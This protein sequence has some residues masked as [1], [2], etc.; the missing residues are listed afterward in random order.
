MRTHLLI[1]FTSLSVF[2]VIGQNVDRE[3]VVIEIG[4]GTWCQWCPGAAQGA[5]DMV[6]NGHDVAVI[7]NH[8]SDIYANTYS[9]AR[10]SYYGISG[11]PTAYFDGILEDGG[12]LMCPNPEGKYSTYLGLY[13][14]RMAVASPFTIEMFGENTSGN[15]WEVTLLIDKVGTANTSNCVVHLVL[16][17]SHIQQAWQGC[18]T[19][20][21]FV[22]RLMVPDQ[23]GTDLELVDDHQEISLEFEVNSGW[24]EDEIEVVA[25]IQ[26]NSGHE[27]YQA[28][29]S[30][31]GDLQP[32]LEA[33]FNV[34]DTSLCTGNTTL[35]TDNSTGNILT[36]TWVFE[37]GTP[38]TSTQENPTVL[39]N[40]AGNF[41]VTL[42][43]TDAYSSN[44][45]TRNDHIHVSSQPPQTPNVPGGP[46]ELC[47]N[48]DNTE[49][50]AT[51]SSLALTYNWV[52]EPVSAGTIVN[53]G[54]QTISVNWSDTF[55]GDASLKVKALNGCGESN[56]SSPL[57]IT[58]M[59]N[60]AIF[61]VTGGGMFCAGSEGVEVGLNG[62]ELNVKYRLFKNN[63]QTNTILN[64]TGE[65]LNF[66]IFN[67]EGYY[68][69][70]AISDITSCAVF[71]QNTANVNEID[72][73]VAYT[74][75]GGGEICEGE[76]GLPVG[77]ED[78]ESLVNYELFLN[79]EPT[80][81]VLQGNGQPLDFGTQTEEGVYSVL[82]TRINFPCT[83]MMNGP[84]EIDILPVPAAY[85]VTGGGSFCEGGQ[86]VEVGLSNS[87]TGIEYELYYFDQQTGVVVQGTG[88]P[89]SFG[90]VN[91]EGEYSAVGSNVT[92]TC[93]NPM[94]GSV[95]VTMVSLPEI[96]NLTGTGTWCEGTSGAV[97]GLDGSQTGCTYELFCNNSTTGVMLPGT[98]NALSFGAFTA[99]GTYH[100]EAVESTLSCMQLMAGTLNVS[101]A[102]LPLVP[103]VPEGPSSVD[104][105]Y[106]TESEY[107]TAGSSYSDSY[108]W[109]LNPVEAGSLEVTGLL[110]CLVSW[111]PDFLGDASIRVR[112]VNECGE[113]SWSE[114]ITVNVYSTV[115]IDPAAGNQRITVSPNPSNGIFTV[116]GQ[117][118][119]AGTV[120]LKVS[121]SL[122]SVI[123]VER[124]IQ[125]NGIWSKEI[126]LSG[127][128]GGVYFLSI[129]T[130]TGSYTCKL[131]LNK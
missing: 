31:L 115:G 103:L 19:E 53:N 17:E 60:P 102:F 37:G 82:A 27:I 93:I 94:N 92:T 29:C 104:L 87:E 76:G 16:T 119:K 86:G 128:P 12:G 39:Y 75:T 73:P 5:D 50:S 88:G 90:L 47:E 59:P 58:V 43:V 123:Y 15:D 4:T 69:V 33:D 57:P 10:N 2:S 24:D 30:P 80:G 112:G 63:N 9:N 3:K 35:F 105:M 71:M 1:L 67:E 91:D 44:T 21:N 38:A 36:W 74:M 125:V 65:P 120:S 41:D 55:D 95:T 85:T 14:Q 48:G 108:L 117:A 42:T 22:N 89:I 70:K 99:P 56:Y 54:A 18:M 77:L 28:I 7:E 13:N 84:V 110:T 124:S 20:V 32:Q 25:F 78:S 111:D 52:L 62:S 79:D 114:A 81:M 45:M 26:N 83:N 97:I 6:E 61:S 40:S 98:G 8:N 131:V 126:D 130:S 113:G 49:Y 106:T 66:G 100:A 51:G 121:S 72:L 11:Y 116:K 127:Q 118:E 96:F 64:G 101:M 122:N 34:S 129:E 46:D 107:T 68:S 23:N 109:D